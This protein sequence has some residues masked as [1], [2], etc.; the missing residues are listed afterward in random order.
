MLSQEQGAKIP[1]TA[2][3]RGA[4]GSTIALTSPCSPG[5][6]T[7]SAREMDVPDV[8]TRFPDSCTCALQEIQSVS[9]PS[10]T[11]LVPRLC[12]A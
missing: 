1:S 4:L 3:D 11:S 10:S 12:R 6:G 8:F 7:R 2:E 9:P 5:F